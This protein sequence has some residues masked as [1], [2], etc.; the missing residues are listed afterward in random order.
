MFRIL[1]VTVLPVWLLAYFNCSF[2]IYC[3]SDYWVMLCCL[4]VCCHGEL[5]VGLLGH[6]VLP[7]GLLGHGVCCLSDCWGTVSVACPTVGIRCVLPVRLLG[8]S[9]CWLSDCWVLG[10]VV[11]LVSVL[12][13]REMRSWVGC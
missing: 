2:T 13:V 9:V 12:P 7:V 11:G 4:S 5:L 10:F 8:H 3:L 6:G 1:G